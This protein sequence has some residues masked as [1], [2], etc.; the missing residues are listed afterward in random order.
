MATRLAYSDQFNQKIQ[1]GAIG[2][3]KI[4]KWFC[5][6]GGLVL[7]VYEKEI[8]DGKGPRLF[9]MDGELIAPD[10]LVFNKGKIY[11]I[12]AKHKSVFSWHRISGRWVTGIDVRHYNDYLQIAELLS[13]PVWLMF[14]HQNSFLLDR[15]EPYPC[16]TGLFGEDINVLRSKENHRSSLYGKEGMVYWAHSNLKRLATLEEVNRVYVECLPH[17]PEVV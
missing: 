1:V 12:E 3:S 16:P 14:L 6:R 8:D 13:Y 9:M 15:N 7:P 2:Q 11:W 4:A 10:M 17:L 5:G